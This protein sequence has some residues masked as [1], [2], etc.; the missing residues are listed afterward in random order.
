M[1]YFV[2]CCEKEGIIIYSVA[3]LLATIYTFPSSRY[4]FYP[5]DGGK[6]RSHP[7]RRFI[8][9]PHGATSQKTAFSCQGT[10]CRM[11]HAGNTL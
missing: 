7:K 2:N 8:L 11:Q 4:F 9:N 3:S 1:K 10:A 5:E 6:T